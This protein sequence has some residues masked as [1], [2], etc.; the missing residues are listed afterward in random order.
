MEII[1]RAKNILVYLDKAESIKDRYASDVKTITYDIIEK[2]TEKILETIPLEELTNRKAGIHIK[3]LYDAGYKNIADLKKANIFKIGQIEGIGVD[4]SYVIRKLLND[5]SYDVSK[6]AKLRISLDNQ[7]D[8]YYSLLSRLIKYQKID[9]IVDDIA[10][11]DTLSIK[12]AID[13][14]D[15]NKLSLLLNG[16]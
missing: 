16:T 2:E 13:K 5:I 4:T 12:N 6:Q 8:D 15:G 3:Y 14:K 11:V 9:M 7:S 1:D 10:G